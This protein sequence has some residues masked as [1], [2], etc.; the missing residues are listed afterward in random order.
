MLER[1]T[2]T[3][4]VLGLVAPPWRLDGGLR[5]TD[6]AH[7]DAFDEPGYVRI[8]WSF[9]LAPVRDGSATLLVTETRVAA[10]D[11]HARRR[12][13]RYWSVVGPFSGIVRRMMLAAVAR[14]SVYGADRT[15]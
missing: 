6:A 10:T 8:T 7:F 3:R 15:C 5:P 11:A 9:V 2:T 14:G 1:R 12:F 13:G 4:I